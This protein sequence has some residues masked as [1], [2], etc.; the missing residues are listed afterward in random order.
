MANVSD[1]RQVESYVKRWLPKLGLSGWRVKVELVHPLASGIEIQPNAHGEAVVSSHTQNAIL[2]LA[3]PPDPATDVEV[4]VVHELSHL[5]FPLDSDDKEFEKSYTC[6]R[7]E[8]GVDMYANLLVKMDRENRA[9]RKL[10][11]L[12]RKAKKR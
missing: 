2:R 7:T 8:Q 9:H 10:A 11:P 5:Y 4:T 1:S 6:V 12:K 3:W